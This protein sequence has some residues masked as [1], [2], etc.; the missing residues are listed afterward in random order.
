MRKDKRLV[1]AWLNRHEM[2]KEGS[3][4]CVAGRKLIDEARKTDDLVIEADWWWSFHH[5]RVAIDELTASAE[6]QRFRTA[7]RKQKAAGEMLVVKGEEIALDGE[8]LW[9]E[10]IQRVHGNIMLRWRLRPS[11]HDFACILDTGEE[12]E[13]V[14]RIDK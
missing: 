10:A 12:F 7:R 4:V 1:A 8:R 11:K 6:K 3:A 14:G 9:I 13:P 5:P 2:L